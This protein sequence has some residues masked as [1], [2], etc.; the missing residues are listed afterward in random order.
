MIFG[1]Q[2]CGECVF[3]CM[4]M[5]VGIFGLTSLGTDL[6]QTGSVRF[7]LNLVE[8]NHQSYINGLTAQFRL[9]LVGVNF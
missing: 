3:A 8:L 5:L 1:A 4:S 2:N 9:E 7:G 6:A